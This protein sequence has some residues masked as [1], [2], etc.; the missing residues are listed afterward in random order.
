MPDTTTVPITYGT[1]PSPWLGEVWLC[2]DCGRT[3]RRPPNRN[4]AGDRFHAWRCHSPLVRA[5]L[6][7]IKE[8]TP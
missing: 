7:L 3:L 6:T 1:D 5:R 2:P 4:A 8:T